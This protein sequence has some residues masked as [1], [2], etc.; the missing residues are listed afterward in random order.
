M[1]HNT[2]LC[3]T[4]LSPKTVN[5]LA[6]EGYKTVADIA[7]LS[8]GKMA[9]IRGL[10]PKETMEVSKFQE[11]HNLDVPTID[12][13]T[14]LR[15]T[16]LSVRAVNALARAGYKT[17]GDIAGL[18]FESVAKIRGLGVYTIEEIL[19]FQKN[20][21]TNLLRNSDSQGDGQEP[22]ERDVGLIQK[23]N[24]FIPSVIGLDWDTN[25]C[26]TELSI[27]AVNALAVAGYKKVGDIAELNSGKLLEFKNIGTKTTKEILNFIDK[28]SPRFTSEANICAAPAIEGDDSFGLNR[29]IEEFYKSGNIGARCYNYCNVHDVLELADLTKINFNS[30]PF[31]RGLGKGAISDFLYLK[32]E[33]KEAVKRR[34][35]STIGGSIGQEKETV[36]SLT[37]S[38]LLPQGKYYEKAIEY[39]SRNEIPLRKIFN[40]NLVEILSS[41]HIK[42]FSELLVY[43][44]RSGAF[45]DGLMA[46]SKNEI[47]AGIFKCLRDNIPFLEK[48]FSLS[49]NIDLEL[50]KKIII[51]LLRKKKFAGVGFRY[52]RKVLP[53]VVASFEIENALS[54]LLSEGT[55]EYVDYAFYYKF[56]KYY[57]LIH[58][59][60]MKS[61]IDGR[62]LEVLQLR[63]EGYTL[64][65]VASRFNITRERIRQ[66]QQKALPKL[67][68]HLKTYDS[69]DCFDEDYFSYLYLNYAIDS[70]LG[71]YLGIDEHCLVYLKAFCKSG[72]TPIKDALKDEL[73]SGA[74]KA[75]IHQYLMRKYIF[76]DGEYVTLGRTSLT[77][78]YFKHNCFEQINFEEFVSKFNEWLYQNKIPLDPI[79]P[80]D[81][82]AFRARVFDYPNAITSQ[83]SRIRY[84]DFDSIDIEGFLDKID[85]NQYSNIHI[86]SLLIYENHLDLMKQYDIRDHYELHNFLRKTIPDDNPYNLVFS[87]MPRLEFGSFDESDY[88]FDL[89]TKNPGCTKTD[90]AKIVRQTQGFD[91]RSFLANHE[92]A[93]FDKYF[94][95]GHYHLDECQNVIKQ[96]IQDKLYSALENGI[97]PIDEVRQIYLGLCPQG[98]PKDI[99][100]YSLGQS[101]LVV[102]RSYVVKGYSSARDYF[103]HLLL[104]NDICDLSSLPKFVTAMSDFQTTFDLLRTKKEVFKFSRNS[105]IT[106][107]KLAKF[108][109]TKEEFESFCDK[110][111]EFA[112]N[113]PLFSI[114][115]AT[116][117][118]FTHPLLDLGFD[119]LLYEQALIYDSEKRFI[120][121]SISGVELFTLRKEDKTRMGIVDLVSNYSKHHGDFYIDDFYEYC[122]SM[123]GIKLKD[124][125]RYKIIETIRKCRLFYDEIMDK[126]Y[127]SKMD[128]YKDLEA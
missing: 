10:G 70:V 37:I 29:T 90:I 75:R 34:V 65:E 88:L 95:N 56:P 45:A 58:S 26:D 3:D 66:I 68:K 84:Y 101:K 67:L 125:D 11:E 112:K 47:L 48:S 92:L 106:M 107:N 35:N 120:H 121:R 82:R 108:G 43:L 1:E 105:T 33:Y 23:D 44:G 128:Y 54:E 41:N 20:Y 73:I 7:V 25:L 113:E 122:S 59:D 127:A 15:D 83:W 18:S 77:R 40:E 38:H 80:A 104:D 109:V 103:A 21:A 53:D 8:I 64:E 16:E 55:I 62:E 30:L 91:E 86:S 61:I 115:T 60:E 74:Q 27:R 2:K 22:K 85:L 39:F 4:E 118:N 69:V 57:D 89:I 52:F 102:N 76:I 117:R 126:A 99:T 49:K 13:S 36:E 97:T 19:A 14:S 111:V 12:R 87:R 17:A 124:E 123:F 24:Q 100:A 6:R 32:M 51:D 81:Y 79:T 72:T 98:D 78:H 28:C 114:F 96:D 31:E 5:I 119:T 71:N 9:K 110:F 116:S 46:D 42:T 94:K 50:I 93:P 63:S